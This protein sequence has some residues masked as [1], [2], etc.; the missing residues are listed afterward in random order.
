MRLWK[1]YKLIVR[2]TLASVH[3]AA[4]QRKRKSFGLILPNLQL[5]NYSCL[6]LLLHN[7][8]WYFPKVWVS[9]ILSFF[10]HKWNWSL[11]NVACIKLSSHCI[12]CILSHVI[13]IF[14]IKPRIIKFPKQFDL[15]ILLNS[16][17]LL[18]S[19]AGGVLWSV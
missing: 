11:K 2:W 14:T 9:V 16:Y 6:K 17:L 13:K 10:P 18:F 8:E 5:K 3:S 4:S 15:K 19:A 12:C 1:F 7:D